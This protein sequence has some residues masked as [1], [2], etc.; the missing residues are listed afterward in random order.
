M[1]P[2]NPQFLLYCLTYLMLVPSPLQEALL[3]KPKEGLASEPLPPLNQWTQTTVKQLT[4]LL[5]SVG[6]QQPDFVLSQFGAYLVHLTQKGEVRDTLRAI[7]KYVL[8][9]EY[10]GDPPCPPGSDTRSLVKALD[11]IA[12][13]QPNAE[14]MKRVRKG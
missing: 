5:A 9:D 12:S 4:A 3:G 1:D 14:V 7:Q 10:M 6:F 11:G 13:A 2:K 8:G